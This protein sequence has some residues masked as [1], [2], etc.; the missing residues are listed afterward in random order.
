MGPNK[1]ILSGGT[2]LMDI[3]DST[4]TP[5]TLLRGVVAYNAAGER[6]VGTYGEE[7]L[8]EEYR[9]VSAVGSDGDN[10][11]I[12][13]GI[14]IH[15]SLSWEVVG[16]LYNNTGTLICGGTSTD[17]RIGGVFYNSSRPRYDYFWLG[18]AYSELPVTTAMALGEKPFTL[19]QS[20][21]E[22]IIEQD[23]ESVGATYTGSGP[24][25]GED[26]Y[27]FKN[28]RKSESSGGAATSV[29][30]WDSGVLIRSMVAAV[31]KAD[32]VAGMYDFVQK[33]FYT[34][35]GAAQLWALENE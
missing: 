31:R 32:E 24:T 2:V 26:I 17:D 10:Q 4:V 9:S 19:R 12:D 11:Y 8:P 14:A 22:V 33:K 3:T 7:I 23:G 25:A 13:L 27:L 18:A 6:I 1:V 28:P 34:S 5:E 30:I 21:T 15:N 16:Q 35:A 29:K 20:S